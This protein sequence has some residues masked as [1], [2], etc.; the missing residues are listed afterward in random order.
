MSTSDKDRWQRVETLF[1]EALRLPDSKRQAFLQQACGDDLALIA[2]VQELLD[3]DAAAD[4]ID[5]IV[6]DAARRSVDR[7]ADARLAQE[8][9]NYRLL[10]VLGEGGMGTVYLAERSD[11]QFSQQLA[12]KVLNT[13]RPSKNLI[14]RL[15]S[16]RQILANLSHPNIA[17]LLD[18]GS[19]DDGMPFI[20]MEYVDGQPIDRYC[21]DNRLSLA[22][23]LR[24]FCKVCDAVDHAHRNL[25]VHRDLKPGNIL[26]DQ[27]GEPKLLDFGIAKILDSEAMAHTMAITRQGSILLTPQYASPEQVRGQ[28]P[29]IATDVYSLGVLLYRLLTGHSP[30]GK[31][32]ESPVELER[33][34]VEEDPPKPSTIVLTNTG[35]SSIDTAQRSSERRGMSPDRLR[36]RLIGDLDNIVLKTLQKDPSRR[37]A[38]AKLLQEDIENYLN[39]RPVAARPDS[40][41]YRLGKAVRRNR[42]AVVTGVI[43]VT[44]IVSLVTFYTLQLTEERD[45]ARL[46]A[47]RAESVADF[48]TELFEEANPRNNF[49]EPMDARQLLDQGAERIATELDRQPELKAALAETIGESYFVMRELKTTREFLEPL[50][51]SLGEELGNDHPTVLRIRR[52]YATAIMHLGDAEAAKAM[53]VEDYEAWKRIAGPA[54][55]DTGV[56]LFRIGRAEES[57]GNLE[58]AEQY[59]LDSLEILRPLGDDARI[60]ISDVLME[61]GV[62]LRSLSRIEEE[63]ALLFE[64]LALHEQAVGTEHADYMGIIN[65][66]GSHYLVRG[67]VDTALVYI[68][69]HLDGQRRL[70]GENGAAYGGALMNYANVLQAQSRLEE[71]LELIDEGLVIFRRGYGEDGVKFAYLTENRSNVLMDLER[72][73]EAEQGYLQVMNILGEKFGTDHPEYAFTQNSYGTMLERAGRLEDSLVQLESATAINVGA[74]GEGHRDSISSRYKLANALIKA[75]RLDEALGHATIAAEAGRALWTDPHPNFVNALDVLARVH[76]DRG[77]YEEAEALFAEAIAVASQLQGDSLRRVIRLETSLAQGYV[78]SGRAREAEALLRPRAQEIAGFDDSWDGIR[79]EIDEVLEAGK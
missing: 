51:A 1:N 65:N 24:L 79:E 42:L 74:Y 31:L 8:F 22:A 53:F 55:H 78:A 23:R 11:G 68:R 37:Y 63:E 67:Q 18:G 69:Q 9:G 77:E 50:V 16:E 20:A 12:I 47:T 2:E 45:R 59:Y 21:D 36:K 75:S 29:A 62:L 52:H 5:D 60:D 38:T 17:T 35:D 19:T 56:A 71:A 44:T 57:I 3:A 26:I 49:G 58:E 39:D 7:D 70:V 66:L 76:R 28:P 27:G 41:A 33:A 43:F 25:I 54:D 32:T 15:R 6:G 40:F 4:P 10:R 46:Q 14:Q 34:I 61:Y 30:Y 48:L 73:D 13:Y 64:A 72:Y